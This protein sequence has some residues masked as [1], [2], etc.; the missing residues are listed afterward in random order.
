MRS[1][2]VQ[3]LGYADGKKALD[4]NRESLPVEGIPELIDWRDLGAVTKVKDQGTCGSCYAFSAIG[5]FEG[6]WYL[7]HNELVEF[8]PQNAVDCSYD[9]ENYG[10]MGGW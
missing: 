9:Y 4:M 3:L 5:S 6:A 1:E 2:Y 10:C 8:S 7:K